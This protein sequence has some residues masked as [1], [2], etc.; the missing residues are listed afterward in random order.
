[1]MV[2]PPMVQVEISPCL[3]EGVT[4]RPTVETFSSVPEVPVMVPVMVK[5]ALQLL[6]V[7][8]KTGQVNMVG[9]IF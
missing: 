1:M 4:E 2:V 6:K 9:F 5:A 3:R 8:I 7:E